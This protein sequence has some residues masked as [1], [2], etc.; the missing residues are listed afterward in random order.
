VL[1]A[2]PA[3]TLTSIAVTPINPTVP[4]G[5]TQQFTATGTY[6]DNSTQNITSQVSWNSSN[7]AVATI[8]AN[9]LA[10][11]TSAG[12][13]TISASQSG[14]TGNTTLTMQ[15][16]SLAVTTSSLPTGTVNIAYSATSTGSGG[17]P[18][19]AWSLAS[20]TLPSGLGLSASGAITGTP[21]TTGTSNF[22]AKV[23]DAAQNTATKPLNITVAT[24]SSTIWPSTAVPG[25]VDAGPDSPVELGVKFRSDVPGTIRGIRF[26]KAN[27]NTGTHIGSLWSSTG[28][29]LASATFTGES[30]SGWQQVD[31]SAP[32]A[33]TA[34]TTYIASYHANTGHY[35]VNSNYFTNSGVDNPPLHAL[36]SGVSGGNGV[37]RYAASSTFP[38]QSFNSSNY[39]V[40]VSFDPGTTPPPQPTLS[41][42]AVTPANPSINTGATQQF[43]ATGTYSNGSTQNLTS[44]VTWTSSSTS[45]ATISSGG[46]ASGVSAGTTTITAAMSGVSSAATLTVQV[47]SGQLNS[48]AV[49]PANPSINTG[50]TQQFTATGTY[51][52]GSTQNLT[53]QVTWTS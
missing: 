16:A 3:P 43:T 39:W 32:V 8:N 19:Y 42:I 6:S 38:D 46:L 12:S 33:I 21:T 10:T 53:S 35:S 5:A 9:G 36:A 27:A 52:N 40:D 51:S 18:P 45:V 4:T 37:F 11:G 17:T 24:A 41:S 49:T 25:V 28:T 29:L 48:I 1:Q 14:L 34:N 26:Y 50:A 44:Q 23:T 31:F 13:T 22:T 15:A 20:G 2:G 30:A 47:P 7:T